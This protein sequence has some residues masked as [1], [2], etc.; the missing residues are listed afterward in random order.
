[1]AA[2]KASGLGAGSAHE[3]R[4]DDLPGRLICAEA[5]S[6]PHQM[7]AVTD[8]RTCAG[9]VLERGIGFEALTAKK[10]R[11]AASPTRAQTIAVIPAKE[12]AS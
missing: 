6:Q 12:A 3:A 8:G 7:Q 11:S 5:S 10:I 9:F 1:M 4:R 2:R